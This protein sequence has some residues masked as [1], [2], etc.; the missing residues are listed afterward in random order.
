MKKLIMI[1]TAACSIASAAYANLGTT[2]QWSVRHWGTRGIVNGDHANFSWSEYLITEGYNPSGI[3]DI[4]MFSHLDGSDL[5]QGE[6]IQIMSN[7]IPAGYV[8]RGY[9]GNPVCPTW[10]CTFYGQNWYA[11]YY[12]NS[13][14]VNGYPV[15]LKCLRIGTQ[16]ALT[17]RGYFNRSAPAR[18]AKKGLPVRR[19]AKPALEVG[20]GQV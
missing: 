17:S 20:P 3:C 7:Q 15:Y 16:S 1:I 19:R 13:G 2:Y 8:W 5:S 11:M 14:T 9:N 4:I 6:I 10:E 12:T 18:I